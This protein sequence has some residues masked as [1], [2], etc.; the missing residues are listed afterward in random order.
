MIELPK[1]MPIYT[2]D[3]KQIFDEK[4]DNRFNQYIREGKDME[5]T[6]NIPLTKLHVSNIL[7][8]EGT[9]PKQENEHNAISDA[10]WNKKLHEFLEN[11]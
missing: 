8:R 10:R 1:G 6:R 11:I 9:Y 5:K 2:K 3:L 7:K 4:V